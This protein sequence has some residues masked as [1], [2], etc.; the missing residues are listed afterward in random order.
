MIQ[1]RSE[2]GHLDRGDDPG[3]REPEPETETGSTG[4][5]QPWPSQVE[6]PPHSWEEQ[7]LSSGSSSGLA[8]LTSTTLIEK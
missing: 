7:Q 1:A 8:S 4:E 2:T 6:Q 5:S 3:G